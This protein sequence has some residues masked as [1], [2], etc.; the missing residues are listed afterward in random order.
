MSI[1]TENNIQKSTALLQSLEWRYA[2]KKYDTT[3]KICDSDFE[4]LKKVIQLVPTSY[5][6]QPFHFLVIENPTLRQELRVHAWNQSQITD[7][8]H[9]I[10]MCTHTHTTP[11]QIDNYV[12]NIATTRNIPLENVKGYGDFMKKTVAAL[13]ERTVLEWNAKQA[14]I[15]L[16]HVLQSAAALEI[17]ATPME[18]Y[19]REKFD[20]ILGLAQKGLT[21]TLVCVFGYRAAD[22]SVQFLPKVRKS[23]E[24]LFETI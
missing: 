20:E 16:G 7:A 4:T 10:V 21:A 23:T 8:S 17:D 3:K 6:L 9:L 12:Q 18:G 1:H 2:T 14:Y 22:D 5:G 11:E 15:A 19:S 13:D 24:E